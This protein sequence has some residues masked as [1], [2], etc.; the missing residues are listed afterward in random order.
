MFRFS[1][2]GGSLS[3]AEQNSG[4]RLKPSYGESQHYLEPA[5]DH[6][7]DADEPADDPSAGK[8]TLPGQYIPHP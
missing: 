1:T 2:A 8:P 6:Q 5:D 7:I 3:T 4:V